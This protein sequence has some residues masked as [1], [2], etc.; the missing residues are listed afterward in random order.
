MSR[1]CILTYL[2]VKCVCTTLLFAP[3]LTLFIRSGS[4]LGQLSAKCTRNTF[5]QVECPLQGHLYAKCTLPGTLFTRSNAPVGATLCEMYPS[6][7][8]FHQAECP[9]QGHLDA[10]C[11]PPG[12]LLFR[13]SGP[14]GAT[15]CEMCQFQNIFHQVQSVPLEG[16]LSVKYAP[17]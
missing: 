9:L 10:K 14:A 3:S 11:A 7:N 12:T 16:Q 13:Y 17:P 15:L 2:I 1:N 8:A 5:H 6:R 4:L